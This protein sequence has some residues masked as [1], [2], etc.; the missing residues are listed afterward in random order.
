MAGPGGVAA[1]SIEDGGEGGIRTRETLL[2]STRFPVALL[3]PLGHLS[4]R[5]KVRR[6]GRGRQRKFWFAPLIFKSGTCN[7]LGGMGASGAIPPLAAGRFAIP[8]PTRSYGPSRERI[9]EIRRACSPSSGI[10]SRR[11]FVAGRKG[12]GGGGGIRTHDGVFPH[13]GFQDQCLKPLGHPSGGGRWAQSPHAAIGRRPPV[14]GLS[15]FA[16]RREAQRGVF[17]SRDA[18]HATCSVL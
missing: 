17:P 14:V 16:T 10:P 11:D 15:T 3:Q 9:P 2:T 4:A 6:V 5:D 13:A 7:P 1:T 8:F 12:D 18:K